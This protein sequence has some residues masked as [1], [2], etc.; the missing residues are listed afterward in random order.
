MFIMCVAYKKK[1][2]Y[3]TRLLRYHIST[4]SM[5]VVPTE[6]LYYSTSMAFCRFYCYPGIVSTVGCDDANPGLDDIVHSALVRRRR[7]QSALQITV[8][9]KADAA[10]SRRLQVRARPVG[11]SDDDDRARIWSS[12]R[13]PRRNRK[14]C[15]HLLRLQQPQV[16]HTRSNHRSPISRQLRHSKKTYI[17]YNA[18]SCHQTKRP[19]CNG[20]LAVLSKVT[21]FLGL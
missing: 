8:K 12:R 4:E 13:S 11:R 16:R 21:I 17:S 18:L 9:D 3:A 1:H 7:Q 15:A 2:L 5:A 19:T 6:I 14:S 20:W 10:A